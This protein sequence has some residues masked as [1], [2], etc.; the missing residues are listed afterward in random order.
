MRLFIPVLFMG[1]LVTPAQAA[2]S[3][4]ERLA[5]GETIV[6]IEAAKEGG[7]A[8]ARVTG[9]IDAPPEKV[10]PHI[11]RC[12]DYKRFLPRVSDSEELSRAGD[13]VR[14]RVVIDTPWPLAD[15]TSVTRATHFVT[16]TLYKRSWALES[17]DYLVNEGSWTLTPHDGGRTLAVYEI[18]S[19]LR[20]DVPAVVRDLAQRRAM[21]EMMA[22]VRRRAAKP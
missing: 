11:D 15:L 17:G 20:Q 7:P 13:Q 8:L 1:A 19:Q 21:P 16:P 9:L 18:R 22:A 6:R 14:C 4:A 5:R 10:W 3:D 2:E 12:G